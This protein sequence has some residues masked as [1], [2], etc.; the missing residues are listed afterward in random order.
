MF[1]IPK[2]YSEEEKEEIKRKLK[3]E[4]NRLMQEK[5]VKKTTVDE[6]VQNVNIPKGTF[7]LFYKSKEMLLFDVL[8]DYHIQIDK[9]LISETNKLENKNDIEKLTD[10][11]LDSIKMAFNSCLKVLLNPYD[12]KILMEKLP[13]EILKEHFNHDDDIVKKIFKFDLSQEDIKVFSGAFRAVMLSCTYERNISEYD[14]YKSIRVLVK[15]LVIQI[16]QKS[17]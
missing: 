6:L 1:I 4:A 16:I 12:I 9:Y 13:D 8:N 5:G 14:F 10:I 17:K 11:I 15:G 2:I 3:A 7:Y